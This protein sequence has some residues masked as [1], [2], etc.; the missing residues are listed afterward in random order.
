MSGHRSRRIA[1]L[2]GI[3]V[4]LAVIAGSAPTSA[5]VS[6][7]GWVPVIQFDLLEV[8]GVVGRTGTF[9]FKQHAPFTT[10]YG[11][12]Y[13]GI[14][15]VTPLCGGSF[16][17]NGGH[18]QGWVLGAFVDDDLNDFLLFY[19]FLQHGAKQFIL[20]PYGASLG[21]GSFGL[22]TPNPPCVQPVQ[23]E[24]YLILAV[25]A[26]QTFNN[27]HQQWLNGELLYCSLVGSFVTNAAIETCE[28]YYMFSPYAL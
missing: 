16:H 20:F 9:V 6:Q 13:E 28:P 4:G 22:I 7:G 27:Q 14:A 23:P 19:G 11:F 1:V 15:D 5:D 17:E 10:P 8:Y 3:M 21:D 26:Q 2:V 18:A 12:P 25:Y 24:G